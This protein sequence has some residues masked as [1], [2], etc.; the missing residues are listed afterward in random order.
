MSQE[1]QFKIFI[2]TDLD[3]DPDVRKFNFDHEITFTNFIEKIQN[4]TKL[5][6]NDGLL[7]Q[8]VDSDGDKICVENSDEFQNSLKEQ[9]IHVVDFLLIKCLKNTSC[10]LI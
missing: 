8:Y 9:V 6:D 5:Y 4:L 10:A 2:H 1:V 3:G 7:I